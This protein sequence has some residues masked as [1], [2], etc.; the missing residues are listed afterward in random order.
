MKLFSAFALLAVAA[1]QDGD[2][3]Q[4]QGAQGQGAAAQGAQDSGYGAEAQDSGYGAEEQ[5]EA[6]GAKQ[7]YGEA[8]PAYEA[9][10]YEAAP[11]YKP[12][13]CVGLCPESAPYF[14]LDTGAC[15]PGIC[16]PSSYAAPAS[17]AAPSGG[18]RRLEESQGQGAQDSG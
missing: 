15:A 6:Y 12:K 7:S 10:H 16:D 14:N 1:A 17:Y 5:P 18:Y 13:I 11:V 3:A 8:A 4:A 9:A 2:G